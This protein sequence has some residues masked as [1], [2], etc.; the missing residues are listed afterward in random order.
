MGSTA[1]AGGE[2]RYQLC[3]DESCE[4]FPCR[5]FKEGRRDGYDEGHARGHSEGFAAGYA[6]GF[7]ATPRGF[8][9]RSAAMME[10][11]T[12]R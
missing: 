5:I 4:R 8:A 7:P 11:L 9:G 6:E 1:D 3:R 12:A 10:G 2:H